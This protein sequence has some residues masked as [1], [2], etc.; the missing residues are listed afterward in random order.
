MVVVLNERTEQ[1]MMGGAELSLLGLQSGPRNYVISKGGC[2]S[3]EL[4]LGVFF[5]DKR[6]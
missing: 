1:G 5:S 4:R 3:G 2:M 6:Q